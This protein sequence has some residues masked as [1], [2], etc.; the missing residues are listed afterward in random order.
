MLFT[1]AKML[2]QWAF[3]VLN[4][5]SGEFGRIVIHIR[6]SRDFVSFGSYAG[7]TLALK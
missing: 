3:I 5:M 2:Q 7:Q 6:G 1:I 4:I